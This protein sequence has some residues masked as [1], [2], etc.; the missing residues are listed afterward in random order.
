[1]PF[2]RLYYHLVGQRKAAR[3]SSSHKPSRACLPMKGAS[4]A[5]ECGGKDTKRTKVRWNATQ[6]AATF[7][8]RASARFG[9]RRAIDCPAGAA[10]QPDGNDPQRTFVRWSVVRRAA[11]STKR[12][13][14]RFGLRR[15]IHRPALLQPVRCE[16]LPI[17]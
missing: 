13:S 15:A 17:R 10:S 1:M 8:E 7:A 9:L 5:N 6:A 14:A 11:L 12:A 2:W 16:Q 4:L 3:P